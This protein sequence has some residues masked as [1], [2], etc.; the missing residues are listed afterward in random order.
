MTNT[1]G[2]TN[3]IIHIVKGACVVN[4]TGASVPFACTTTQF[5]DNMFTFEVRRVLDAYF[6]DKTKWMTHRI[7]ARQMDEVS[8]FFE[9]HGTS[10][11]QEFIPS[12][13]ALTANDLS[14]CRQTTRAKST[15]ALPTV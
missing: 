11:W 3:R 6:G 5:E 2:G 13:T 1:M 15:L 14:S 7:I 8:N 12:F 4:Y 10:L 9:D